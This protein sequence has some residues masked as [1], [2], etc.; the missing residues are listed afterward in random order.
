MLRPLPGMRLHLLAEAR[1]DRW[2]RLQS[3]DE[4]LTSLFVPVLLEEPNGATLEE[5]LADACAD[6]ELQQGV[7]V[8][9]LAVQRA[10]EL[11]NR[12]LVNEAQPGKTVQL[13]EET[14]TLIT[15]DAEGH[16]V[17]RASDVV[18]RWAKRT[19]LRRELI[20]PDALWDETA[21][22]RFFQERVLGQEQAIEAVVQP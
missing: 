6:L 11:T 18:Q 4:A 16:R 7:T 15:P 21:V 5:L 8:E 19:G 17:L 2:R 1:P 20:D 12:F 9:P 10:V 14:A 22:R 3:S 13:L